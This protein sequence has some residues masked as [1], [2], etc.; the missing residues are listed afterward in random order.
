MGQLNPETLHDMCR[1][2]T[3]DELANILN[4]HPELMTLL[5]GTG[6][7]CLSGHMQHEYRDTLTMDL[8]QNERQMRTIPKGPVS[9][10]RAVP[11][12]GA[13]FPVLTVWDAKCHRWLRHSFPIIFRV[14]VGYPPAS[15]RQW[16]F[17]QYAEHAIG[18][19]TRHLLDRPIH[20]CFEPDSTLDPAHMNGIS[21]GVSFF[22]AAI[23]M[24]MEIPYPA[25]VAFSAAWDGDKVTGVDGIEHKAMAAAE[26][27]CRYLFVA[28][29][30]M[31]KARLNIP[32]GSLMKIAGIPKGCSAE[33]LFPFVLKKLNRKAKVPNWQSEQFEAICRFMMQR[34]YQYSPADHRRVEIIEWVLSVSDRLL[35]P[36]P[37]QVTDGIKMEAL[38]ELA[39]SRKYL[40]DL[41]ES[42]SRYKELK[43]TCRNLEKKCLLSSDHLRFKYET[44]NHWG[45]LNVRY[46]DY[47]AAESRLEE[48]LEMNRN[49]QDR[50]RVAEGHIRGSLGQLYCFWGQ[51]D[52]AGLEKA[53]NIICKEKDLPERERP[54][55]RNYLA[56]IYTNQS[57][58]EKARKLLWKNIKLGENEG[59]ARYAS[60]FLLRNNVLEGLV[61]NKPARL[62]RALEEFEK[63]RRTGYASNLPES[64]RLLTDVYTSV[65]LCG[66]GK[67]DEGYQKLT[68][69]T[70][71]AKKVSGNNGFADPLFLLAPNWALWLARYHEEG[72]PVRQAL[73]VNR[74][75]MN[76]LRPK[77]I[78][79]KF[80]APLRK[81]IELETP[82]SRSR[83]AE[84]ILTRVHYG[85]P[86]WWWNPLRAY[87]RKYLET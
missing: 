19:A 50:N 65:A 54:R 85:I 6:L 61:S 5:S 64:R 63:L 38:L 48:C 20:I 79:S 15:S 1:R 56:L 16:P 67:W 75:M 78:E 58:W 35:S 37:D 11:W 60:V 46:Y 29:E 43:R 33:R 47:R 18:L 32:R 59:S 80:K 70:K 22:F 14:Q 73:G 69:L 68:D 71:N 13:R 28:R 83:Q 53:F 36:S 10:E 40:G 4:K 21:G 76:R 62:G 24:V 87:F 7:A 42:E 39:Q 23:C 66:I 9:P 77:S 30:D 34:A 81:T 86:S 49:R 3:T 12:G 52:K 41:P 8:W 45:T 84:R 44:D 55:N 82:V 27:G 26:N 17:Y 31:E 25:G 57:E 51:S 2:G 74:A 72:A